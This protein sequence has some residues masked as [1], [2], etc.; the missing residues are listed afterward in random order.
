MQFGIYESSLQQPFVPDEPSNDMR[1][2]TVSDDM[3]TLYP[4]NLE[5]GEMVMVGEDFW[6]KP[7]TWVMVVL[8]VGVIWAMKK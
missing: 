4:Q 3:S 7:S 1:A 2:V 6:S 8:V 5:P